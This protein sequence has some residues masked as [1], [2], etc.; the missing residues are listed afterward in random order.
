MLA[1]ADLHLEKGSA[2]ARNGAMLPPYDTGA[3]LRRLGAAIE[4]LKP[5]DGWSASATASTTP[6]GRTGSMM[7]TR[8][9]FLG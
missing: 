4:R 8:R 3:T 9:H 5:K 1:V 7:A 2:Y 6:T